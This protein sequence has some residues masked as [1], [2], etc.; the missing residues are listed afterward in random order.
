[1]FGFNL[2]GS[3]NKE[4][5]QSWIDDKTSGAQWDNYAGAQGLQANY[6][7]TSASQIGQYLDP[8]RDEVANK[9]LGL[10]DQFRQRAINGVGDQFGK[11]GAF[12]GSRHGVADA[13]TNSEFGDKASLLV[14]QLMSQG[15]GQALGAAQDENRFGFQY[16]L[17]RQSTLNNTLAGVTPIQYGKGQSWGVQ[18]SVGG[19][20]GG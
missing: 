15:F 13:L 12:G 16:P 3:F 19:K 1:M 20:W 11:M 7:P 18:G 6:S 17:Q 10:L 8:Y 2:G 4:K 5:N 14:S 9:S